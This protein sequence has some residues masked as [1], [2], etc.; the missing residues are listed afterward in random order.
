MEVENYE[1]RVGIMGGT[2]DPIH[3]GH[4]LLAQAAIE[5]ENLD[6]VLFIPSGTPWLKDSSQVLN[7]KTRVSMTGIAIED[8]PKFALSTIEIDREGNSYSYETLEILREKH[9]LTC[10]YF[11][12]GA[13]SL[14]EIEKW[15]HPDR[16]MKSCTLLTAVR[17]DC[18]MAALKKQIDYLTDKYN[19]SI[20]ILPT[21]R[22]DISSTDIRQRIRVGKSIRYLLPDQIMEFIEKNHIYLDKKEGK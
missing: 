11:I 16:L 10:Y 12:L 19:A 8:N 5:A 17:D 21:K 3:Y 1:K 4:L 6:E 14:L 20:E 7:K 9:P 22:I 18:D 13:D 2:F 15:K